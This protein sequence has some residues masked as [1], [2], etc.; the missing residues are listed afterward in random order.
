MCVRI[1]IC[2]ITVYD[3]RNF[4]NMAKKEYVCLQKQQSFRSFV[5]QK[6]LHHPYPETH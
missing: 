4:T 1:T 5:A 6:K 2:E 3:M